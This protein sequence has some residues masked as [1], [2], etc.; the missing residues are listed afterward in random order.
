MR[1]NLF[2]YINTCYLCS[3][4]IL[5]TCSDTSYLCESNRRRSSGGHCFGG[6]IEVKN[7]Y[8][9]NIAVLVLAHII[10]IFNSLPVEAYLE[11]P[12]LNKCMSLNIHNQ[13]HPLTHIIQHN[14]YMQMEPQKNSK[15]LDIFFTWVSQ[16]IMQNQLGVF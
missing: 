2:P 1:L 13:K 12:I 15:A 10:Q 7:I 6:I 5:P 8:Q 16:I 11:I 14:Q 4:M 9:N 3:D